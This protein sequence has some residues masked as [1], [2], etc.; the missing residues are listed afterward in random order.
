MTLN[1]LEC[2]KRQVKQARTYLEFGAGASTKMAVEA[3][4]DR[5]FTVESDPKWIERCALD[6]VI[7]EALKAGRLT[8]IHADI[9]PVKLWGY[10][11]DPSVAV[12][13]WPN[14]YLS[15]WPQLDGHTPDVILVDG[16][17]RVS[18]TLQ[19]LLRCSD[20]CKILIHDFERPFYHGVLAFTEAVDG[21]DRLTV[22]QRK[23]R[24][25]VRELALASYEYLFD[26]R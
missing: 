14:Y 26:P 19:S 15:V 21:A 24:L 10:P 20:D 13:K 4:V 7:A 23:R 11:A 16:R 6:P 1:E 18:C 22:L 8:F 12:A 2:L 17:F 9:G 25:D 3:G 5:L